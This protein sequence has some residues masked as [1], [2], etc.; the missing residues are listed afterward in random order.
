MAAQIAEARNQ[1]QLQGSLTD[2][3]RQKIVSSPD[4]KSTPFSP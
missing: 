2:R 4:Y 1:K 3:G